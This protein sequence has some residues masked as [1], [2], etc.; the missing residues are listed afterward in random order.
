MSDFRYHIASLAAVFLALG[1]GIFVGT[2]F[3]GAPVVERQT[4]L[5][6]NLEKNVTAQLQDASEREKN[7]EAL[8]EIMPLLV[9]GKLSGRRVLLLQTGPS[10]TADSV[11]A[12]LRLAGAEAVS[13]ATLPENAWRSGE[14]QSAA[15]T[16]AQAERLGQIL[17]A[18][19]ETL[20]KPFRDKKQ[21]TGDEITGAFGL[22]VLVC[23]DV[24]KSQMPA[25]QEAVSLV[26]AQTRDVPLVR[27]LQNATVACVEPLQTDVSSMPAYQGADVAT[28]DNGDR[29]AGQIALVF[30][31]L[32]EKSNYGF[33]STAE[34][35]LPASLAEPAPAPNPNPAP[36]VAP[37]P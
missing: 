15:E 36:I 26:L 25:P 9:K 8:R 28:I 4:R 12:V 7:E 18:P 29:A 27:G 24:Q 31:L 37:R 3:V 20:L 10:Q 14:Q 13:R 30:A 32:G 33:K 34:R 17:S 2:A 11:A 22:V 5:I 19:S 16:T 21:I 6:K 35:V 1:I 23:G